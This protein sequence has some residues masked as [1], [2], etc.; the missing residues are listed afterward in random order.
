MNQASKR[1]ELTVDIFEAKGEGAE[2]LK[3]V[4]PPQLVRSILEEFS[5]LEYL[6]GTPES[7][8]LM[9]ADTREVLDDDKTL[10]EQL[11]EGGRHLVIEERSLDL[12]LGTFAPSLSLYLREQ[13]TGRTYRL[14]WYPAIVGRASPSQ[15]HNEWVAVDLSQHAT[16][17]RVSR[18][19]VQIMEEQ[20][21]YYVELISQNPSTL[22]R[23]G[24]E[25]QPLLFQ[26]RYPLQEG[27]VIRLDRSEILL[28]FLVRR[29]PEPVAALALTDG[30]G[31]NETFAL[32]KPEV[33]PLEQPEVGELGSEE[34]L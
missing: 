27:D 33:P 34:N 7:Y 13:Q 5:E 20:G 32:S 3:E 18:R 9:R 21:A 24:Q 30:E 10:E 4:R 17:P 28:K 16:A 14:H 6:N 2:V 29:E 8:H 25:P 11:P 1:L 22:L 26:Q 19:H 15:P 12:P 23:P 31:A